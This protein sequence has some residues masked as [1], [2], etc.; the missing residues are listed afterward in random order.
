MFVS[1]FKGQSILYAARL[2]VWRLPGW[3]WSFAALDR[4]PGGSSNESGR[5]VN[6]LKGRLFFGLIQWPEV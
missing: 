1:D 3:A 5:L 2:C 6:A 4:T